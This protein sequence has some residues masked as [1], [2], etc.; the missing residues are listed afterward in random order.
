MSVLR[1]CPFCG[2]AAKMSFYGASPNDRQFLLSCTICCASL[3]WHRNEAQAIAAWNR[4]APEWRTMDDAPLDGTP[5]LVY[6]RLPAH[7]KWTDPDRIM[8][9]FQS[10]A[11]WHPDAG[12]CVCEVREVIYWQPLPEPPESTSDT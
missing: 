6:A 5:V 12:F 8:Q 9:P 2:A 3:P 7:A 11:A 4:R 1:A 10:V